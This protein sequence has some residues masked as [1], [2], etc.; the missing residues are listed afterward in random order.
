M[1]EEKPPTPVEP[2]RGLDAQ[3]CEALNAF[4]TMIWV[5]D[6]DKLCVWF[7][8]AWLEFTGRTMAREFG[9]GW[10]EGVDP[11][12][13]DRCLAIYT[14]HFDARE[15]F[16]MRYRLRRHDGVYRWID[17]IGVPRFD[18]EGRFLGFVGS[19]HDIHEQV[20]TETELR[21]LKTGLEQ[22]IG[23]TTIQLAGEI[24]A[25]HET[26]RDL[27]NSAAQLELLIHGIK[28]YAIY[29][30]DI[31]GRI[32]SWNSGA[33]RI[34]GYAA[35]EI[36]GRHFSCFYTEEDRATDLP[37]RALRMA[38]TEGKFEAEGWRVRKAGTRFWAGVLIDPIYDRTGKLVGFG[39]VTR[40]L[41]ER[42][43]AQEQLDLARE[44]MLQMQKMEAIGQLTGGVAHDFN[45]LLMVIMGNLETAQRQLTSEPE[46][47]LQRALGNAMQGARRAAT[48]T[49]RMLAFS[50][51]QP[52]APK[53]LNL[54]KFIA[55]EVEFLQRTLGE[56]IEVEAVGG[57]GLWKVEV[58][59]NQLE[60][61]LLNLAVN[62]RDAM[63]AGG[64]LTIE[65][66]NAYLDDDY[67]RTNS[68]V[69]RGQYVL[70]SITDSGEGMT[71]E[72]V[73]SG[74]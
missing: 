59:G 23:E 14:S 64:K 29:M 21:T 71:P 36:I 35:S 66:C 41:S 6:E 53:V 61:A 19:C 5:S 8:K 45:N 74:F 16:R 63:P 67:C 69:K 47:R 4:P 46:S 49:Q 54:N 1:T 52:L 24:A 40:D 42:R 20:E 37:G 12:D 57:A 56:N 58:D 44:S 30:L 32:S 73:S 26:E 55:S 65:T 7:N 50:R 34:K 48:L 18:H 15:K 33:E 43:L 3:S 2:P 27:L 22:R 28:D 31:H 11:A 38:A 62:A 10:A 25:H 51:R 60:A 39:K 9:H 13:F 70:L 72:V 68:D 17:D